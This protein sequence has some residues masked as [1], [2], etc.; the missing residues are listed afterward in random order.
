MT[1]FKALLKRTLPF[2]RPRPPLDQDGVRRILVIGS[3]SA[4]NSER[5]L[6]AVAA[7]FPQAAL[8]VLAP[9][10]QTPPLRPHA[11]VT[12]IAY[13]GVSRLGPLRRTVAAERF[14]LKVA[15]FTGEGH[16]LFKLAAFTLPARRM[17]VYS[18]GGGMFEWCFDQ[19][20]AV[21]NH[22]IGRIRHYPLH[23]GVSGR[24]LLVLFLPLLSLLAFVALLLWHAQAL[25]YRTVRRRW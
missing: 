25:L 21:V 7:R 18:E 16:N 9:A 23:I 19:R 22:V 1:S 13:A 3:A 10:V 2:L 14:D 15:L 12:V 6:A 4:P 17:L 24:P 20:R 11:G 8:S 5:A